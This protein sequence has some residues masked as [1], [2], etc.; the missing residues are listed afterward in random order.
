MALVAF[1]VIDGG[2]DV[3]ELGAHVATE[4]RKGGDQNHGDQSGEQ[5]IFDSGGAGFIVGEA[6]NKIL[7]IFNS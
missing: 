5:A 1:R 6:R 4:R 7:H 2:R 3:A